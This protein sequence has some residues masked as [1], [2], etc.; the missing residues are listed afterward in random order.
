MAEAL[1]PSNAS[2]IVDLF[3]NSYN[4]YTPGWAIYENGTPKKVLMINYLSDST[5]A[6]DYTASIAIGG[7]T[8]GTTSSTPS[9]VKV[10]YLKAP[11]ITSKQ[12]MTWAG[13]VRVLQ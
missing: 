4:T 12:N 6:S 9:S 5:G 11:T 3:Q 8:T 10:K 1:G 13:Q 2:Q 7:G